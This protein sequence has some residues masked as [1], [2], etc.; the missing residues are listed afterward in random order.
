ML[1]TMTKPVSRIQDSTIN[2]DTVTSH[3]L[4]EILGMRNF[5]PTYSF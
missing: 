4:S 2:W 5:G 1:H 3:N